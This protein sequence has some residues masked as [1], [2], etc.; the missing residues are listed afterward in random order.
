MKHETNL[1]YPRIL[2]RQ[3]TRDE[4]MTF[5]MR[6][7]VRDSKGNFHDAGKF[8]GGTFKTHDGRTCDSTGAFMVG[9]LERLDPELHKP[10][11]AISYPRD[12][13]MRED[14]TLADDVSSFTL[15]TYASQGGLGA[16]QGIGNGKAWAGKNTSQIA[17]VDVDIAKI[18]YPLRLWSLE[19]KYTIPEL[20]SAARLGRPIDQQK[21]DALQLKHQMDIDEQIYIGDTST[22]DTGMLNSSLVTNKTNVATVGGFTTW[23]AKITGGQIDA[24]LA[25]VNE[26]V[27][28]AWAAT[29]WAVVPRE[30]RI[31]PAQFGLISTAKAGTAGVSVSILKY[32]SENSIVST[33]G[34]GKLNIQPLKW[35][36]GAG[37][38]GTIGTVGNDRMACYTKDKKFLR[39]PMTMIQRTPVQYDSL[40]HKTTYFCRLGV[41]EVV[42]P[43]TIAFRDG[44]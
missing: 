34:N 2:K 25:D 41:T 14:V 38:G 3:R 33:S 23:A 27:T 21:F 19:V 39:Y 5:G 36:I 44:L 37:Q 9:E 32:L 30:L 11:A 35:C 40:W 15:S 31:P 8:L 43:E 13:E 20:E 24:L 6:T 17:G 18:T 1:S 12:M 42:Y 16:G 28:S 22:G 7:P 4:M 10:L 26:I 29:G